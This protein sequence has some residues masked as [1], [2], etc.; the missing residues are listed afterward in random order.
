MPLAHSL[1]S[2]LPCCY[3]CPITKSCLT[4]CSTPGFPVL[5]YLFEL[6]QMQAH[7][8]GDAIQPSHP[9]SSPSPPTFSLSQ[10][11]GLF[12]WVC[13]FH[14]VAK[15]LELQHQHQSFPMNIQG[16]FPLGWTGLISLQSTGLSRVFSST[17]IPKH[18]FS[19]AHSSL[20]SNPHIHTWL[21]EKPQL[22]LDGPL[23][24]QTFVFTIKDPSSLPIISTLSGGP[25]HSH[26]WRTKR[27]WWWEQVSC[28]AQSA[29]LLA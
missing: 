16:Y 13:P 14:Q 29:H 24:V 28:W 18:Q 4:L 23:T 19:G 27:V 26:R 10:Q 22:W 9:L 17:T 5:H 2:R 25:S 3:C 20:W 1:P 7:R 21:L 8:V 11:Q 12:P 15:T 6:A